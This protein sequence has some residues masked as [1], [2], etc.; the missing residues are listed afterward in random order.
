VRCVK[1]RPHRAPSPIS[2]PAA[3]QGITKAPPE[4]DHTGGASRPLSWRGQ[5]N[6]EGPST[7]RD[8]PPCLPER[9]KPPREGGGQELSVGLQ[10]GR[11]ITSPAVHIAVERDLIGA[12]RNSSERRLDAEARIDTDNRPWPT[13]SAL[14][15]GRP[16]RAARGSV[17]PR[18]IGLPSASGALSYCAVQG[19]RLALGG[20][21]LGAAPVE[22]G[23]GRIAA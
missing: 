14:A 3:G 10:Q 19:H 22:F 2:S 9:K 5:K 11:R 1:C 13:N 4:T 16:R 18:K 8:R 15:A 23:L 6:D 17:A 12:V 20:G 21:S 7:K